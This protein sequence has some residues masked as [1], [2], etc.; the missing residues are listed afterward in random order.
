MQRAIQNRKKDAKGLG[1]SFGAA[2][3]SQRLACR[4]PS[5]AVFHSQLEN[6]PLL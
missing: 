1:L 5:A 3:F 6:R 2:P 4:H